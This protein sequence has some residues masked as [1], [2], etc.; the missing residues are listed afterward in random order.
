MYISVEKITKKLINIIYSYCHWH[1]MRH[2]R[3]YSTNNKSVMVSGYKCANRSKEAVV[4]YHTKYTIILGRYLPRPEQRSEQ[5][6]FVLW[7]LSRRLRKARDRFIA[8]EEAAPMFCH[9]P[10][11][12]A[13]VGMSLWTTMQFQDSH[14]M[15]AEKY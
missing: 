15:H 13:S 6:L 10:Y 5:F 9:G 1:V 7:K 4:V 2:C 12:T 14:I 8:A 3:S 11:H